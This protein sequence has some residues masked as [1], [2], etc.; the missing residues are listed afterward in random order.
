MSLY[1]SSVAGLPGNVQV[2]QDLRGTLGD[3][4]QVIQR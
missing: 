4:V 1:K 3:I 2:V